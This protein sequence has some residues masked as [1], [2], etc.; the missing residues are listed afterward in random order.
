VAGELIVPK[1]E[2]EVPPAREGGERYEQELSRS[3]KVVGNVMITLSSITPASSVFIIIPAI[4]LGVGTGS[5]LA[6]LLA[7]L[8]GVFMAFCW[9]ELCAAFPIAGG[10]YAVVWHAFKG[11]A[12]P[13]AG[14]VSMILFALWIDTIVFIPAVIALGTAQYLGVIWTVDAKVAGAVVMLVAA[15]LAILRVR[16]NAVLT[17]VMLAIEMIALLMLTVLGFA[18]LHGDRVGKLF[19]GWVIGNGHGGTEAVTFGAILAITA[20]AV[21]AYN[22][23]AAPVNL[24]EETRGSSRGIARAILWSLV[25]TVLAELVPTTAVLL[26]A[27]RLD[28][29]TSATVSGGAPMNAFL[30]ATSSSAVNKIVSLGITVA[31]LNAV[32]AIVIQFGRVLYSSGR[33]RA[34]PGPVNAWM[35]SVSPRFQTPWFATALVGVLGAILCLTVSLETIITLTGA[36]LVL[37]YALVAVGAIVGR[38]SGATDAS[39]YRMPAWPLPPVLAIAALVYITTKQTQK[40]VL[41]TGI[42]MLIGLI[43]WAVVIRPQK[44]RAWN[45][46]DP[47]LDHDE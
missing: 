23:Y 6:L 11:R 43:Y 42:T 22:G 14:P 37:N 5:F 19:S 3:L 10:D 36:T 32:I 34:W 2:A 39:P 16:V 25:I 41:V 21:F 28:Q 15:G 13:L 24:S 30:L 29:V 18:H 44:G 33:D 9:G 45:L 1:G 27:P 31:I 46:K 17:G 4:L 12:K 40:S 35:S 7:A 47:I 8:V 20:V 38:A 26:G